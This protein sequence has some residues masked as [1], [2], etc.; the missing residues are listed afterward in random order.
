[1][2]QA[3]LLKNL[4]RFGRLL[5]SVGLDAGPAQ[6]ID[7]A[8]ALEYVDIGKRDDFYYA[9]RALFAHRHADLAQFD[10]AFRLFWQAR[11]SEPIEAPAT[12]HPALQAKSLRTP[13]VSYRE[14]PFDEEAEEIKHARK[15]ERVMVEVQQTFS[16]VEVLRKKNFD[17]FTWEEVQQAKQLMAAMTWRIGERATRRKQRVW[18]G[19]HLDMRRIV[20]RNM[21]YGGEFL[22]LAWKRTKFKPR[23]LVV[24]CDISGSME[25]YSRMLLHFVHTLSNVTVA[26]GANSG[27]EHV[28]AFLFGTRLTRIT[29]QIQRKDIDEAIGEVVKVVEDWGGGTRSG[30]ALKTFN[31][32]W[33]R[34]VA[35]RGAIVLIISDGWDRGD[36]ELLRQEMERLQRSCFRLIWLNP[37]LALPDY[38]PMTQ[39]LQAALPYV[40]DFLPVHNLESLEMLGRMLSQ[41]DRARPARQQRSK[42]VGAI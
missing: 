36:V 19:K 17:A 21:K 13:N 9:A 3:F 11:T 2:T 25:R 27:L 38:Q 1:M 10:E 6:V 20:R 29:R 28:E 23:P 35:A 4:V 41:L 12:L 37:L 31:Y 14:I 22:D 33:A 15:T 5:R 34:R 7:L 8:A 26:P 39:G 18:R 32:L 24:L 42:P 30:D 40:D 16:P